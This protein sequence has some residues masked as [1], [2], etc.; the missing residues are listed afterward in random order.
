MRSHTHNAHMDCLSHKRSVHCSVT[1]VTEASPMGSN[2][3]KDITAVTTSIFTWL[4]RSASN[5]PSSRSN[6]RFTSNHKRTLKTSLTRS[7]ISIV[8]KDQRA[9]QDQLLRDLLQS[10]RA[11]IEMLIITMRFTGQMA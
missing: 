8:K 10:T 2:Y 4:K 1:C 6:S 11:H 3:N 5:I 9:L 7:R